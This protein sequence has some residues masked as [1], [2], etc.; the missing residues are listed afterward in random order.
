MI[1]MC[2]REIVMSKF[3]CLTLPLLLKQLLKLI[4]LSHLFNPFNELLF[5][6]FFNLLLIH[7]LLF[8]HLM[9]ILD[10]KHLF[11]EFLLLLL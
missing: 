2:V 8:H 6:H 4:L 9:I 5:F 7:L 1:S 3:I 11:L 10:E